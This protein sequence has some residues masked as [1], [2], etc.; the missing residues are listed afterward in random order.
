MAMEL[1]II[2]AVV[3]AVLGLRYNVLVLLPAVT[4]AMLFAV[5]VG[6]ARADSFGSIVLM[7]MLLGTAIQLGYLA[8]IAIYAATE[9]ICAALGKKGRD[10]ELSAALGPACPPTWRAHSLRLTPSAMVRLHQLRPPQ[11]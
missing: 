7:T 10:H 6:M 5:V 11:V 3:G 8:G 1:A 4:F 9:A 2:C